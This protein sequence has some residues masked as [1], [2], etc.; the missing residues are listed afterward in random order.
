[1][2]TGVSDTLLEDTRSE[3]DVEIQSMRRRLQDQSDERERE[4][5]HTIQTM[6]EEIYQARPAPQE[7]RHVRATEQPDPRSDPWACPPNISPSRSPVSAGFGLAPENRP[8]M[9][10]P[11]REQRG[12]YDVPLPRQMLYDGKGSYDTF[13]RPFMDM[14]RVCKWSM[15]EKV[16][17]LTNSVR[18]E[19]ADFV[20]NQLDAN[21]RS[22]FYDLQHALSVRFR[23]RRSNASFLAELE[24]R[25][26]G[27]QEKIIEYVTDIKSLVRS[28]YPTADG[29][30]LDTIG[31]RHF[32]KGL[33]DQQTVLAVGMKSPQ[34]IEE[35]C[36]IVE[37]YKSLKDESFGKPAAGAVRM[38]AVKFDGEYV[39]REVFR[40]I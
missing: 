24:N 22:S 28:S 7:Q 35:A 20:F 1:M 33:G 18:G 11:A 3:A 17:R 36:E 21:V 32:L 10:T 23:E 2:K 30:T 12:K 4:R 27:Q 37:T 25:K 38:K 5:Q 14:A 31:L 34:S 9:T 29:V 39:K 13:I 40:R 16:F 8:H 15:E 19:A 6:R 26:L